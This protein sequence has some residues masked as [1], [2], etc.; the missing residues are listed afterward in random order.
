MADGRG[1]LGGRA[2]SAADSS[3]NQRTRAHNFNIIAHNDVGAQ[4]AV[5]S[6]PSPDVLRGGKKSYFAF[7]TI[8][9]RRHRLVAERGRVSEI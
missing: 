7:S 1:D 3:R 5:M 9:T 6:E 4:L 8:R 2:L